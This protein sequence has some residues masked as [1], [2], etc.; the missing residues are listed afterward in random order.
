MYIED[1]QIRA[2]NTSPRSLDQWYSYVDGSELKCEKED[3]EKILEHLNGM[4]SNTIH[5]RGTG[6]RYITGFGFETEG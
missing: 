4:E 6:R 1:F 2:M 5:Q 3:S